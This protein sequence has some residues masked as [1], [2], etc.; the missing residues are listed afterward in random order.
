MHAYRQ[1]PDTETV[2]KKNY[3]PSV[4]R[5][6]AIEG[7]DGTGKT[8]LIQ[9]LLPAIQ[10]SLETRMA[11]L[12]SNAWPVVSFSPWEGAEWTRTV[13]QMFVD[14]LDD[15]RIELLMTNAARRQLLKAKVRPALDAGSFVL[16]DRYI[17]TT[18]AYQCR[19]QDDLRIAYDMV[20]DFSYGMLPG[21]TIYL[22][23]DYDKAIARAGKRGA[24][25][26]IEARDEMFH[27][28]LDVG[29][30]IAFSVTS[31]I[32][33]TYAI[34]IDANQSEEDVFGYSLAAVESY[35]DLLF[36]VGSARD[37]ALED[38]ARNN[39]TN[40]GLEVVDAPRE[41]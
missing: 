11:K 7:A 27:L 10:S 22:K 39:I 6:I 4:A 35:L 2:P 9:K 18:M 41:S 26:S 19:T 15:N 36:A 25:D 14:G 12:D 31:A 29:Y 30:R 17:G 23:A 8:T 37:Q 13:R 24:L 33:N 28:G 5:M 34:E 16:M 32:S 21:L 1:T 38:L 20:R 3:V 40:V